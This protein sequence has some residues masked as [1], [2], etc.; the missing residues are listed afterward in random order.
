MARGKQTWQEARNIV[1]RIIVT[2]ELV[3]HSPAHLGSGDAEGT[4]DLSLLRDACDGSALLPGA[5]IAG[6][7]RNY[8]RERRQGYG[9]ASANS[10][11]FG[12]ARG[13]NDEKAGQ[14]LLIVDDA[15]GASP[16]VELRDGVKIDGQT[17]TAAD[18]KLFDVELLRAGS[19]FPLHF[20]LLVPAGKHAELCRDLELAL[21]GLER[22]E[23]GL[24]A[25]K[26]RGYG[27]CAVSDW[28]VWRYD[29]T[30]PGGLLAWLALGR[31]WADGPVQPECAGK[32]LAEKLGVSADGSD[33]R[34]R[35]EIEARFALDGSLLIRSGFGRADQGADTVHLHRPMYDERDP[36]AA[37]RVPIL[38]GTSLAGALRARALRISRTLARDPVAARALVD[39][40]FGVGPQDS[41]AGNLSASRLVVHEAV[42]QGAQTLVQNRIR[43]DRFTGGV[44]DHYLFNEAPIFGEQQTRLDVELV[45]AQPQ[46]HE[47]GLLLLLLKDL[48]LGDLPLGGESGA[49]RGR[50]LGL[51]AR[52]QHVTENGTV[53]WTLVG[54]DRLRVTAERGP[55]EPPVDDVWAGLERY[56][57]ALRKHL[58]AEAE[59]KD[60]S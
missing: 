32:S 12:A 28:H 41:V 46:P 30:T 55:D 49:G 14:S 23:I 45:L 47:V 2:G 6:A 48:W 7:L 33:H 56:V 10:E 44:L 52:L 20:E 21:S 50:V 26:R 59:G 15:I 37:A 3:L 11:L 34:W 58:G 9:K 4:T 19:R 40:L 57:Q 1:E 35:F 29:L 51:E 53:K 38:P 39:G 8:W 43:V 16:Q 27:R 36:D 18:D 31:D 42:V 17:R 25:R 54:T 60:V 24:G 22:G 5:S 13:A